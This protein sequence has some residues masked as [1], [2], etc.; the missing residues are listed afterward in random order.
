MEQ[1]PKIRIIGDASPEKKEQAEKEIKRALF[2]HYE[3]V[4]PESKEQLDKLECPKSEQE[5]A[6]IDF[7]NR[8]TDK[9]MERAGVEPYDIPAENYHILPTDLYEKIAGDEGTATTFYMRQGMFF[10]AL[11][12]PPEP[13]AKLLKAVNHYRAHIK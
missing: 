1:G 11:E 2:R 5:L 10:D 9:L 4:P 13:N 6:L 7:A 8:E 3:S 12:N